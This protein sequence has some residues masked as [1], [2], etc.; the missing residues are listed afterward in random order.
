MGM[1][2]RRDAPNL[3]NAPDP[4]PTFDAFYHQHFAFVWRALR[5][6]GVPSASLDDAAQNVFLIVHRRLLEFE[7]RAHP[8]TWL[9]RIALRVASDARRS[10]RRKGTHDALDGDA[11]PDPAGGPMESLVK[12]E[13]VARLERVLDQ[14][15]DD[16]RAVFVLAE[17]EQMTVPEIARALGINANTVGS[18]LRAARKEFDIAL[19]RIN[20]RAP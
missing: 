18:R 4:A 19:A 10:L 5:Q 14:L 7:G 13:A 11:V 8:R 6:L 2:R 16:K 1:D 12:S 15:D 9:F 20:R 3:P 17:L